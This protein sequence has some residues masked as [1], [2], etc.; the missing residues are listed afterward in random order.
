[1]SCL[2]NTEG[3]N[4]QKSAFFPSILI[5]NFIY[6]WKSYFFV[7]KFVLL[8]SKM[9]EKNRSNFCCWYFVQQ[10]YAKIWTVIGHFIR[11]IFLN[12]DALILM[13]TMRTRSKNEETHNQCLQ[14]P[15]KLLLRF[16]TVPQWDLLL[17][18]LSKLSF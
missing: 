7:F 1:M 4:E 16:A 2:H 11:Q 14:Q 3:Q 18:F 5:R 13:K 8:L 15:Q 6:W 9:F 10:L 12:G 17:R